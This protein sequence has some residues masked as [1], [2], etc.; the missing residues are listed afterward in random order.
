MNDL[1]RFLD[2]AGVNSDV[3]E[4]LDIAW[5]S[6]LQ[7]GRFVGGPEVELFEEQFASYC[8]ASACV[9]VGNGTDA[10]QLI[11]TAL[12]IG[13]GDEVIV[14]ANTFAATAEAVCSAGARPRFVDVDPG[15]LLI[16]PAAAD[17]AVNSRTA[18]IVGVHLFGQM[19]DVPRVA[20]VARR[21]GL[22]LLEDAAQAHGAR[23][24]GHR[25]GSVG[26]AAA[27]S[28]YPGKN[29]GALGDAGAVVTQDRSIADRVRRLGNHGCSP[30]NRHVHRERGRNSRLDSIQAA[31]L[32][33]KLPKL[34]DENRRRSALMEAYAALL[35]SSYVPVA[36][37][38]AAQSAHHLA[39]V[40]TAQ[41]E[42]AVSALNSAAI[43]WGV[44]YPVP[45]HLQPA[46]SAFRERLPT[47]ETAARQIL[48]LPISPTLGEADVARICDVL[49]GVTS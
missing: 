47:V 2:V 18:A 42:R 38:P 15:T 16:D 37:S 6:V 29:L 17:A 35:P 34:D 4:E 31:A 11:L 24:A 28:F 32:S 43:G 19:I 5:K 41:R 48:S 45:C 22:A 46:F 1:I 14:P 39:V 26:T 10:L 7:H 23:Y 40:R 12:S 20:A 8:E 21:H 3:R 13:A 33:A 30:T 25:A 9:G 44:H 49:R 27:F 36:V